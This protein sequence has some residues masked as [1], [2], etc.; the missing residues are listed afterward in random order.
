MPLVIP[1]GYVQASFI[2]EQIST[3]Q[4]AICT[5]GFHTVDPADL[6]TIGTLWADDMLDEMNASFAY[7]QFRARV[8]SGTLYS[9]DFN[10]LGHGGGAG[11]TPQIAYLIK[12]FTGVPGRSHQGRMYYPGADEPSV[13]TD[14]RVLAAKVTGLQT[15][16]DAFL[17][18][19]GTLGVDP[20]LLHTAS[21]DAD[22]VLGFTAQP[23]V[24]TQRR[25]LNRGI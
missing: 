8:A 19:L 18:S 12:K 13:D 7:R 15:M 9:L 1:A 4:L 11:M 23:V 2:H 20:V 3:H 10:E 16:F 5:L 21:S 24:A 6:A 17:A 22:V 25:R 14:G